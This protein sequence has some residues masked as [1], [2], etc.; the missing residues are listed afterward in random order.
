MFF[1]MSQVG[2]C[3]I[4]MLENV[5]LNSMIADY[6]LNYVAMSDM[7]ALDAQYSITKNV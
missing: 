1:V 2:N 7:H 4:L 5:L 6:W 3:T